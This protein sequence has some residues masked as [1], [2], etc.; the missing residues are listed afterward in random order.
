MT[1]SHLRLIKSWI[2]LGSEYQSGSGELGLKD[3]FMTLVGP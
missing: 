2:K 3:V 1:H